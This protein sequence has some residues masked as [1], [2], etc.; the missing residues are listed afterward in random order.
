MGWDWLVISL[1]ILGFIVNIYS[2]R[3]IK[4]TFNIKLSMF[5]TL[6]LDAGFTIFTYAS[7]IIVSFLLFFDFH[8]GKFGCSVVMLATGLNL[9]MN[10]ISTFLISFIRYLYITLFNAIFTCFVQ[11]AR[12]QKIL[13]SPGVWKNETAIVKHI[14]LAYIISIIYCGIAVTLNATL[15]LGLSSIYVVC[16]NDLDIKLTN[17]TLIV[18]LPFI[19]MLISSVVLDL[20]VYFKYKGLKIESIESCVPQNHQGKF[21][22]RLLRDLPLKS[23]LLN[24]FFV[25]PFIM[26]TAVANENMDFVPKDR[27]ISATIPVLAVKLF[28]LWLIAACTFKQNKLD[29]IEERE[30]KRQMEIEAAKIKRALRTDLMLNE[31]QFDFF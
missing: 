6:W 17:L 26:I 11:I 7:L 10:P 24:S 27:L 30:R 18:F 13:H 20:L 23:S 29:R 9:F 5:Y 16:T 19:I 21:S 31:S 8:P 3:F 15:D 12:F 14:R 22:E 2:A 4:T 1:S 25:I 28:R